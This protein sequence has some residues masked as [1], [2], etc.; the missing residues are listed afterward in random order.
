MAYPPPTDWVRP[1]FCRIT[2]EHVLITFAFVQASS[3]CRGDPFASNPLLPFLPD[4]IELPEVP[5]LTPSSTSSSGYEDEGD[6]NF[7]SGIMQRNPS[8]SSSSDCHI[9]VLGQTSPR[10]IT[11]TRRRSGSVSSTASRPAPARS[12]L[13]SSSSIRTKTGRAPPSVKFLDMPTIHYEEE[14]EDE[15]LDP[16]RL[17]W[18]AAR[19]RRQANPPSASD[20]KRSFGLLRWL[21]GVSKKAKAAPERPSISRPF[22]LCDAPHRSSESSRR[23]VSPSDARS[24]RSVRSMSSL[25]SIRSFR[26]CVDRLQGFWGRSSGADL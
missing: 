8:N 24:I 10:I 7:W 12:I 5:F 25:R 15:E 17:S 16:E 23:C 3:T 11:H 14:D 4:V 18:P 22:P 2:S 26:S 1:E 21:T 19:S 6:D 13:S 9:P 20:K